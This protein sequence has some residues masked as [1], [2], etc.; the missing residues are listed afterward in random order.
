M[1]CQICGSQKNLTSYDIREKMFGLNED[2]HYFQCQ[3]CDCLQIAE[4]PSDMIKYYPEGYYSYEAPPFH[5]S[6]LARVKAIRDRV[7]LMGSLGQRH[8]LT[9]H[10]RPPLRAI[11]HVG[12]T[13]TSRIIDVGCG[14]G[15]LLSS[16]YEM[17]V[18]NILGVDPYMASDI[19]QGNKFKIAI[20]SLADVQGEWDVVMFHH[21][22]EHIVEQHKTLEIAAE[23]LVKGGMCIIRV[24]T[25]S[26]YAWHHYRENWVQIDAPRHFYLHSIKS[27]RI[28]AEK[29]GLSVESVYHDSTAFQ[30]WG[31]E[32]YAKG[33]AL[34]KPGQSGLATR[35]VY[36]SRK[37]IKVFEKKAKQLNATGDGDQA[38]FF[39][40]KV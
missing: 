22:F 33:I 3:A 10:V 6:L 38:A 26:S 28:L 8:Y 12:L 36:F 5:K 18:K 7:I 14:A 21:S 17:G 20:C 9:G 23:L 40:R 29:S 25:V 27:M 11:A 39:L 15:S 31:S 24:P 16:L 37:E 34:V 2:F 35:D 4:S 1:E 30:F 19:D 13:K 32:L